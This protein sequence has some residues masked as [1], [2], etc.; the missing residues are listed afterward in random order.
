MRILPVGVDKLVRNVSINLLPH[1]N[2]IT[3]LF[4][5][6]LF[7]TKSATC[8]ISIIVII[9]TPTVAYAMVSSYAVKSCRP[10]QIGFNK[11]ILFVTTAASIAN[12]WG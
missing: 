6:L 8:V 12:C 2:F 1:T 3:S 5:S 10:K 7:Y 9:S 11:R 4:E